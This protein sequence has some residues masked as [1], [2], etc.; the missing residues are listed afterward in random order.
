[1]T[2]SWPKLA[3]LAQKTLCLCYFNLKGNFVKNLLSPMCGPR[4][5]D[6]EE[7]RYHESL[8]LSLL[9]LLSRH[10]IRI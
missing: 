10:R 8:P 5:S 9:G 3:S 6:A 2:P 1:M 4:V 7:S